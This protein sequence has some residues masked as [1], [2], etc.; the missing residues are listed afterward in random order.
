MERNF[1]CASARKREFGAHG[2]KEGRKEG[3][4]SVIDQL[5]AYWEGRRI[6]RS[7]DV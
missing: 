7:F 5:R 1:N 4:A 6:R 3:A 2:R